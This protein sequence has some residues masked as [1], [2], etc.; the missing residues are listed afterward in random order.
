MAN[1]R[2]NL[3][4]QLVDGHSV[5]FVAP[6]DC[7][8]ITG[9]KVYY[10]GESDI[11][12]KTFVFK[13]T[14]GNELT[15]IGNLFERGAYVKAILDTKKGFAYIQNADTNSYLEGKFDER[16]L[17]TYTNPEQLGLT[18][19]TQYT[20][21]NVIGALTDHSMFEGVYEYFR[22]NDS[23]LKEQVPFGTGTITIKKHTIDNIE[24]EIFLND[25]VPNGGEKYCCSNIESNFMSNMNIKYKKIA[26]QEDLDELNSDLNKSLNWNIPTS[27]QLWSNTF[28]GLDYLRY[29]TD[30]GLPTT[31]GSYL[32][33]GVYNAGKTYW[34][35]VVF[36]THLDTGQEYI[37]AYHSAT[38]EW[39]GWH[40]D[41][42]PTD[43]TPIL[44][45]SSY[46]DRVYWFY[47][48]GKM[49]YWNIRFK[50]TNQ[51]NTMGLLFALPSGVAP[52]T[53]QTGVSMSQNGILLYTDNGVLK[54]GRSAIT[55]PDNDNRYW[56]SSDN[57]IP[58]GSNI[59]LIG[60]ALVN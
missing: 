48:I 2:V 36:A 53:D 43:I 6:C 35:N 3:V 59:T 33:R 12:T 45:S 25:A 17:K 39:T 5:T 28:D 22:K 51:I 4:E 23:V 8:E 16:S 40:S 11:E 57:V 44:A 32:T 41:S 26:T 10:P 54:T 56:I 60:N 34:T 19:E 21:A 30:G 38:N 18:I 55:K 20:V 31:N 42:T 24:V 29:G 52:K 13:D 27:E 58:A 14:H 47:R 15:G 7:T 46:T 49:Y 37:N 9:L 1:I 50:N